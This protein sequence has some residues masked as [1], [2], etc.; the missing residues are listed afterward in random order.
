MKREPQNRKVP[1]W[2]WIV[3]LAGLLLIGSVIG[4]LAWEAVTASRTPPAIELEVKERRPHGSGELVLIQVY[5][6]GGEVAADLKV[7][8]SIL[9]ASNVLEVR[10]VTI[11]YVPRASRK[12]IGLFFS[13]PTANHQL[14]LE[15]I[16]FV[17]P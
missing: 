12:V 14:R 4:L 7:R 5:N 17:E 8:G 3:A 10:E 1:A 11:D 6:R 2:E 15:P 13:Q 9:S 16:G